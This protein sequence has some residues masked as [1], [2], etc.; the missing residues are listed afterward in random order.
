MDEKQW[1]FANIALFWILVGAVLGM[2]MGVLQLCGVME[3][4]LGLYRIAQLG[5]G[6]H[7]LLRPVAPVNLQIQWGEQ[8]S[9]NFMRVLAILLLLSLLLSL[10]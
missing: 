4:D 5:L 7:L 8:K 3:K 1:S 9:R 2:V 6:L 10:F